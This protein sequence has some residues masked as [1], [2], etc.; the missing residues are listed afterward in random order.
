MFNTQNWTHCQYQKDNLRATIDYGG[1]PTADGLIKELYYFNIL[2]DSG[3]VYYAKTLG[4]L[5]EMVD[6]ANH[7]CMLW[8]FKDL[9]GASKDSGSGCSSC[10]AKE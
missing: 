5:Q 6:H 4:K 9:E 3:Q 8:D 7:K 1:E 10:T 2:D